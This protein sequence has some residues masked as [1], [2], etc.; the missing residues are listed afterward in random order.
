MQHSMV[1]PIMPKEQRE[2]EQMV[3]DGDNNPMDFKMMLVDKN[4][5]K[6]GKKSKHKDQTSSQRHHTKVQRSRCS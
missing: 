4:L 1:R 2:Y 6:R 5:A 3:R